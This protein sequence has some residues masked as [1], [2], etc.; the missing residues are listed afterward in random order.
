MNGAGRH[1]GWTAHVIPLAGSRGPTYESFDR[2]IY[3][4]HVILMTCSIQ[5][6]A[7]VGWS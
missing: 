3:G 2:P 6:A 1:G 7:V 5:Q 4:R